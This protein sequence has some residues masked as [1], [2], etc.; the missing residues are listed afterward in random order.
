MDWPHAPKHWLFQPGIYIVT[1][2]T[3]HK[4]PHLRS[5]ERKDFF[6]ERLF[7]IAKE[8]GWALQAWAILNNHYHFV[9]ASPEDPATLRR[10]IAKLHMT[11]AKAFNQLD[12]TPGRKVWYQ[13]WDTLLTYQRSYLARLNYVNQNPVKHGLAKNAEAYRWCSARWFAQNAP[14]AFVTSVQRFKI[15]RVNVYDDF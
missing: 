14:P 3:Y 6:L 5:P 9:A 13:Y 1:A 8:F 15:D 4:H 2:A 12:D 7:A 11:T 10:F